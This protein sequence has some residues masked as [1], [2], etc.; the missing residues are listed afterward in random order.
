MII[1]KCEP[2]YP[3]IGSTVIVFKNVAILFDSS[4]LGDKS[5]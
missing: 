2:D 1:A 4:C 3:T 5:N